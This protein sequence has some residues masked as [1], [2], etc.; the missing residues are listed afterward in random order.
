MANRS[1]L[2]GRLEHLGGSGDGS[3]KAGLNARQAGGYYGGGC[4]WKKWNLT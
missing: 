2:L 4:P 1:L 3:G